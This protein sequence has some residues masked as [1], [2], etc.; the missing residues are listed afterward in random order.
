MHDF[1]DD[2]ISLLVNAVSNLCHNTQCANCVLANKVSSQSSAL[3]SEEAIFN[4]PQ[5]V[6]DAMDW[7]P[8]VFNPPL[9]E[10]ASDSDIQSLLEL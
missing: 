9:F 4:T 10:G 7:L 3:C 8:E 1:T 2:D 6:A 5:E